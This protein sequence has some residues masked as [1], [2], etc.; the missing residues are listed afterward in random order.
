MLLQIGSQWSA[1]NCKVFPHHP[2]HPP[3]PP[4]SLKHTYTL[5]Y[6]SLQ[7]LFKLRSEKS[8]DKDYHWGAV[9]NKSC[10]ARLSKL[11]LILSRLGLCSHTIECESDVMQY[12]SKESV[13]QQDGLRK[14]QWRECE[15][16]CDVW[17][18]RCL[19]GGVSCSC[20]P[21]CPVI[22]LLCLLSMHVTQLITAH[23][24]GVRMEGCI[25][26]L[27]ETQRCY[28]LPLQRWAWRSRGW[29]SKHQGALNSDK[30][31]QHMACV[32]QS[33]LEQQR[34]QSQGTPSLCSGVDTE[35]IEI[36]NPSL[37]REHLAGVCTGKLTTSHNL[38][39]LPQPGTG[40]P[41]SVHV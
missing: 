8:I 27:A 11:T 9:W 24:W 12:L 19:W 16:E 5:P 15:N 23:R 36:H 37:N 2:P 20:N 39:L 25:A 32:S 31:M 30:W 13:I 26:R 14:K 7:Q 38:S 41:L 21:W 29:R 34:R 17:M 18:Q 10:Q 1:D 33:L 22:L 28:S 4:P 6:P 40:K 3:P 35:L